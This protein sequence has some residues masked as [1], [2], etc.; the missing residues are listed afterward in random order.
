METQALQEVANNSSMW[1]LLWSA[2]T[3]TKVVLIGLILASVWSWAII[4]EKFGAL[5]QLKNKTEKFEEKLTALGAQIERVSSD[6][7]IQK[8]K[9]KVS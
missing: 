5:R 3:V 2:D 8:F 4:F 7:E 1:D 9:L 6:K